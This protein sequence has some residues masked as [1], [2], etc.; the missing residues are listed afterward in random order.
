MA[1]AQTPTPAAD[2]SSLREI[3]GRLR[4]DIIEMIHKAGSG[5]PGGSLSA[6]DIITAL[7]FAR[8]KHFPNDPHNPERDRFVLSKGH[9]VPALYAVMAEAGYFPKSEL[10]TLRELG[11]RLQGHP[12]NSA[13]P[14]IEACTG[15][16][17]QG[18]SV[19][20]GMAL[21]SK[22]DGNKFHVYCMI[23]DGESQE[24]QI[25]E[26]AMSAVK[27]KLDNLTVFLDYNKGQIDGPVSDVMD[28]EPI[29]DKWRAFRWHVIGIDGH[30][31]NEIL[32]A[33]DEARATKGKPTLIIANTV[34]GKGVSFM[35]HQIAWH[36]AA[37]NKD[38]T[39]KAL[40]EL[41]ALNEL[42]RG[43]GNNNSGKGN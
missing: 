3:A 40:E 33:T 4:L 16:L 30:N 1:T 43:N 38:Q 31:F 36:G 10:K 26:A 2:V 13:L 12:V 17:G 35:E 7:Y 29:A 42:T 9:A 39:D 37:P 20:Q 6:I 19:A 28:L 8:M 18:L 14:G 27:F 25:W 15:S 34:K 5:H 24:G 23:G 11:S 22:L 41:K 21:A 32:K